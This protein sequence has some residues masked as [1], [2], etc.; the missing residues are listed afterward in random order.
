MDEELKGG[1]N[2]QEEREEGGLRLTYDE[3]CIRAMREERVIKKTKTEY[4]A[5]TS[6]GGFSRMILFR[7]CICE[8]D[9]GR[10]CEVWK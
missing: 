6:A 5:I 8:W 1:M 2:G 9:V 4:E 3:A 10:Y 7:E